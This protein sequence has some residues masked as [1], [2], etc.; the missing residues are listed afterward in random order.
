LAQRG[1]SSYLDTIA[2]GPPQP[3]GEQRKDPTMLYQ[4][5]R[6]LVVENGPTLLAERTREA[7]AVSLAYRLL[8]TA[9][10]APAPRRDDALTRAAA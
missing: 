3:A 8:D 5:D 9:R 6:G 10:P 2:G 7:L 4:L 1:A